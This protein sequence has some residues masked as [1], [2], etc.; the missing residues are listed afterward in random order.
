MAAR[1]EQKGLVV[2]ARVGKPHG[3]RGEV[4]IVSYAD[5]PQLF[6][7]VPFIYLR[8]P[9]TRDERFKVLSCRMHKDRFLLTLQGVNDRNRAEDLKGRDVAVLSSD[10]PEPEP[11]E[12]YLHQLEGMTAR[13]ED[14]SELGLVQG[15]IL[16]SGQDTLVIRTPDDREVLVPLVDDFIV[17]IDLDSDVLVLS[18]PEGLVELYLGKD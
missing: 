8:K 4:G 9:G 16:S 15:F 11:G 6:D 12:F 10:L 2:V 7:E 1:I 3:I 13:L 5:S 17:D 18:P 14:G